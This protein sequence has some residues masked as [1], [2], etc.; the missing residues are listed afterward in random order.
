MTIAERIHLIQQQVSQSAKACQREP[1]T[2][3][4]MA[5]SKGQPVSAISEA[6]AA[7]LSNIGENYWQEAFEK[8]KLLRHLPLTWHFIGPLQSNKTEGIARHFDWVHSVD[9]EKIARLLSQ[10]RPAD[11]PPLNLCI[12][13]NLDNE[14]SKSGIDPAKIDALVKCINTLPGLCLRGFMAIPKPLAD[15]EAQ[16][17]SLQR[18]TAL[19]KETNQRLHLQMDTLSMGMSDDLQAA[20]RA[21]STFIRIGR[22]IFGER[23]HNR[24]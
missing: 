15:E 9:R 16:Y 24:T 17:A 6:F 14:P 13:I 7:G 4:I 23:P 11:K 22:A 10:A 18:L 12:Q 1:Q 20:I 5:V 2:I 3:R 8:M 21:G 19:L